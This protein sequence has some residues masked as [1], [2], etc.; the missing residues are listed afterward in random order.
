MRVLQGDIQLHF[1]KRRRPESTQTF[2]ADRAERFQ[3]S[4]VTEGKQQ[5]ELVLL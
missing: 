4:S 5:A 3:P 1:Q 2:V